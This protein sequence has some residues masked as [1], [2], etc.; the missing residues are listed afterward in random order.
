MVMS[1]GEWL[2]AY[3]SVLGV[4]PPDEHEIEA[5]LGLAG[6]AA[7]ASERT[8]APISC[9]LLARSGKSPAEGVAL[10]SALAAEGADHSPGTT[11]SGAE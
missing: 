11:R 1:A 8:A 10:A 5:L 3:A 4:P 7:H 9:Y 2:Q 6:V